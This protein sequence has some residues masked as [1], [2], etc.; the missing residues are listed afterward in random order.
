MTKVRELE[1]T[2][3]KWSCNCNNFYMF[4]FFDRSLV[5]KHWNRMSHPCLLN[6]LNEL[7]KRK[8]RNTAVV[9]LAWTFVSSGFIEG[10]VL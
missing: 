9:V 5:E 7:K 3:Y 4:A 8:G 6:E 1:R 10:K 2:E